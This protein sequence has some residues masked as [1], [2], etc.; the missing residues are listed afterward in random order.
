MSKQA[1]YK[2][3]FFILPE[4]FDPD[5]CRLDP[6]LFI[7]DPDLCRLDPD[8]C[9]LD[10]DLC[11]LDLDLCRLD[12]DLLRTGRSTLLLLLQN[13]PDLCNPTLA[14]EPISCVLFVLNLCKTNVIVQCTMYVHK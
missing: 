3:Y 2:V 8:L 4:R 10:P 9:K 11:R 5:L 7:L 14:K 6:D 12:P 13:V 1:I